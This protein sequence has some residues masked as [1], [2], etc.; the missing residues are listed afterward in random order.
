MKTKSLITSLALAAALVS[1]GQKAPQHD[2]LKEAYA[3]CFKIGCA[4]D[5]FTISGRFP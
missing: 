1:C 2:S 4:I 3:D 5:P